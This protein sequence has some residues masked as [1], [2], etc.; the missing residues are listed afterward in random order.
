MLEVKK[1]SKQYKGE[2]K[3]LYDAVSEVSLS[4]ADHCIYA[5]VGES[6][7]GKSTLSRLVLGLESP[8]S[9]QILLDGNQFHAK[10]K[11]TG[12]KRRKRFNW[13]SRMERVPLTPILR[14]IR[15]LPSQSETC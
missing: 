1:V 13:Y 14:F 4:M 6:G 5:L 12:K 9:G 15:R 7:C 8:S 2:D 11:E 3:L 10:G